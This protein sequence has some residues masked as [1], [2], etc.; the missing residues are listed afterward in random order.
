MKK[1]VSLTAQDQAIRSMAAEGLTA[2]E[3]AAAIGSAQGSVI[4]YIRKH[5]IPWNRDR[6]RWTPRESA[7]SRHHET[8]RV[9]AEAGATLD[10]I[11]SAVGTTKSR[12]RLYLTK[13]GIERPL[14]RNSPGEHPMSRPTS[15]ALNAAWKGGRHIDKDGYVLLWMP[16]HPEANRHGQVREH[17]IV[18][19]TMLGRPLRPGEV[20][21]HRNDIRDDNRPE[22]LRLFA[23][24]GEH[25][26]VTLTGRKSRAERGL[27]P[28]NRKK[29]ANGGLPSPAEIDHPQE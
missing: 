28:S 15:G 8:V 6:S 4:H 1:R 11:G 16:G 13:H 3:M 23:S 12:V 2:I 17:R 14:W 9:M 7:C 21:D 24:N 27:P 20:V 25:L 29:S 10:A 22:N 26:S 5:Q 19:A 18:M